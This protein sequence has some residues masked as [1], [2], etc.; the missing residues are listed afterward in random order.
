[1]AGAIRL[2]SQSQGVWLEAE[3][4]RWEDASHRLFSGPEDSVALTRDDPATPTLRPPAREPRE[5]VPVV[6][7]CRHDYPGIVGPR[8][9]ATLAQRTQDVERRVD[10]LETILARFM[11]RTDESIARLERIVERNS[12]E[13]ARDR[14][15]AARGRE[16]A[17]RDREEAARDREEAARERREERREMNKRWGELANKMGTVVE[18]IV[19]PS[20]R[21]L[22]REVF[23]CGDLVYFGTRQTV[24]RDDDRSRTREFDALYVGTRAVL[25]N[26]T[27]SS[28]RSADARAFMAFLRSGE[29]GKFFPQHRE[30]PITPAFSSLS[31]PD[32][33]VT[34]L[35]RHRHLRPGHGRRSDAGA[36]PAGGTEPYRRNL[37]AVGAGCRR[38]RAVTRPEACHGTAWPAPRDN[39]YPIPSSPTATHTIVRSRAPRGRWRSPA[40]TAR[41]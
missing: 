41:R 22:A 19:A 21:R 14:E 18:D 5:L 34:Y 40:T 11:A 17:A 29:F 35:T 32:D 39:T 15:E 8:A 6:L 38:R 10:S 20:V 30:L 23:E 9:V 16:E 26:E 2:R 27:K 7:P 31:I 36:Q 4:L 13:A 33:M 12:Q 1:M 3:T 37:T 25:L 28:P 24:T